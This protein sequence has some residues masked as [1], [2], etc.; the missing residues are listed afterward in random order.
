MKHGD[1]LK[2]AV[3]VIFFS[4]LLIFCG[5]L[6]ISLLDEVSARK[7][8]SVVLAVGGISIVHWITVRKLL[9]SKGKSYLV[10]IVNILSILAM[11]LALTMLFV[12]D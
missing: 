9:H 5:G 3:K 12:W 2:M 6:L 7:Y 4:A 11:I 1:S 10:N 8:I